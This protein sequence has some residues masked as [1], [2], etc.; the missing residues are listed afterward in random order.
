ARLRAKAR[1]RTPSSSPLARR[2]LGTAA[3]LPMV[4]DG[5][6]QAFGCHFLNGQPGGEVAGADRALDGRG[7][8]GRGPIAREEQVRPTG[9]GRRSLRGL[10]RRLREGGAALLDDA[11]GR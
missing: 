9:R 6:L 4:V 1:L 11:P 2:R 5:G 7:Q 3:V 10:L 8:A